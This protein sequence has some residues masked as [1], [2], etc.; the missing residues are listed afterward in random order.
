MLI[1]PPTLNADTLKSLLS[2][3]MLRYATAIENDMPFKQTRKIRKNINKLKTLL[4]SQEQMTGT[5]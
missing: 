5:S 2:T 1:Q 3:E 4:K